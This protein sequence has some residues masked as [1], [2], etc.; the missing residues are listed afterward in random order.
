MDFSWRCFP[1]LERT[2]KIK[3]QLVQHVPFFLLMHRM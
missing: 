1:T 3:N 2:Q